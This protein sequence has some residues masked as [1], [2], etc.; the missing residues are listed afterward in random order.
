M[1]DSPRRELSD[2]A[3][4]GVGG[5]SPT[6]PSDVSPL[7]TGEV[8]GTTCRACGLHL[9]ASL[10]CCPACGSDPWA[11]PAGAL[12]VDGSPLREAAHYRRIMRRYVVATVVTALA[13]ATLAW[14]TFLPSSVMTWVFAGV[15]VAHLGRCLLSSVDR[16]RP[17]EWRW[18]WAAVLIAGGL[19]LLTVVDS[20][21]PR[22][23]AAEN[24]A[25]ATRWCD[26]GADLPVP[27]SRLDGRT[28]A[29]N[30]ASLEVQP[31]R[32][33]LD[34]PPADLV[35]ASAA[36]AVI[37]P[38]VAN[39]PTPGHRWGEQVLLGC[40]G[41]PRAAGGWALSAAALFFSERAARART[42]EV[43][44]RTVEY[45]VVR[46]DARRT[47]STGRQSARSRARGITAGG[48][49]PYRLS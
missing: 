36:E 2:A 11:R 23:S 22:A 24:P 26:A 30:G 12:R 17:R 46:A 9:N 37:L 8:P 44:S 27:C 7:P 28:R 41:V 6:S 43:A 25:F 19:C 35:A 3:H 14:Q 45:D 10:A 4:G 49:E 18:F 5:P 21:A 1:A 38:P 47:D 42:R 39:H 48:T 16:L 13:A 33:R 20:P 34:G 32:C 40:P 29:E 31:E 15:A